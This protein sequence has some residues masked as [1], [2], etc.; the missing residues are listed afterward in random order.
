MYRHPRIFIKRRIS[1]IQ[2]LRLNLILSLDNYL[3][4]RVTNRRN[5]REG[6]ILFST[7]YFD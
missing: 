1:Y 5:P 7:E 6:W 3:I 4:T 2:M